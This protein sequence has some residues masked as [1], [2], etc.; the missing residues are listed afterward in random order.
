MST[1]KSKKDI[2]F[3][4]L[5]EDNE[6]INTRKTYRAPSCVVFGKD[7]V[8]IKADS[9]FSF[10][11]DRT[12]QKELPDLIHGQVSRLLATSEPADVAQYRKKRNI[13]IVFSGGPAPGGHNVIAGLYEAAKAANPEN[14]VIGFW[15][16]PDGVISNTAFEITQEKV[17]RFR[18]M[19]GFTM[20]RTSRAKMDTMEK[21]EACR[22]TCKARN[23]DA[24]VIVGGDDSNTN[25][26]FLAQ[27]FYKDGIQVIGVPKTIDGDLQIRDS[28]GNVLCGISFGF[29]TAARSFASDISNLCVDSA[30][31]AKYWHICKVMG[32]VAS[33]LAL[34][35][36]LQTHA[37]MTF[38]GEELA[39]YVD[40]KRLQENK[41]N[42][43][44]YYAYGITLRHL[45]RVICEGIVKRAAVGKNYGVI[46]IPEGLL[47]FINEIQVFIVKLGAIIGEYNRTYDVDF[48]TTFKTLEDK[49]EYLRKLA[50]TSRETNQIPLW[51]P[52]D[53]D[54]LNDVPEYFQEGLLTERDSHGNFQFSLVNTERII[55]DMVKDH[56]KVLLEEGTY[57]LGITMETY[58]KI[59]VND[60]FDADTFGPILFNAYPSEFLLLRP[61]IHSLKTLQT[62]LK[63]TYLYQETP[64]MTS[65]M[66]KLLSVGLPKFQSIMHFYGYDGRG[67]D[68]TPFDCIYTY[69][70]GKTVF[71]LVANGVTGQMAAIQHLEKP[72][73]EWSPVGVP[74]APLMRLEERK[75]KLALVLEKSLVEVDSAA[76]ACY[77]QIREEWLCAKPG[78]D[79]YRRPDPVCFCVDRIQ[80]RPITLLLNAMG[81]EALRS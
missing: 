69:N 78:Y 65:I 34:E 30:S 28:H 20:I 25:A 75:G 80:D 23:L 49:L 55:I 12:A 31:A 9:A 53:D 79:S 15:M 74:I 60:G 67:A 59:M 39:D 13:G 38:I 52:R 44:D 35:V 8:A 70:L 72:F 73:T 45:S 50:R 10:D 22:A 76:L 27:A 11:I 46:I 43:P 62:V 63:N 61:N 26:A 81:K 40:K 51:G 21:I 18:N 17:D 66:K 33:H 32:R 68:P 14:Q 2:I 41:E 3:S 71:G 36:G 1:L 48:H 19:G 6:E 24:L 16:G 64:Q 4:L 54:W 29:D 77:K 47:E 5:S 7:A 58:H 56:L 42:G 37:N 57:R